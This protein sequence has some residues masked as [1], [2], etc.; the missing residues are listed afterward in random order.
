MN[1]TINPDA[2]LSARADERLAH[3][4][5]QIARAD[6]ELTRVTERLSRMESEAARG[7][8]TAYS[9]R[10]SRGGSGSR[11]LIAFLLAACIGGAA[12]ASHSSYGEAGR[13]MIA[14]LLPSYISAS[15]LSVARPQEAAQQGSSPVQLAAADTS[16]LQPTPTAQTP[17][18]VVPAPAAGAAQTPALASPDVM[19]MLQSMARD[20]ATVEQGIEQLKANQAQMAA[21]NA[22]AIEGLRASQEQ[23]TH[24][25]VRPP[26]KPAAKPALQPATQDARAKPPAPPPGAPKPVASAAHKPPPAAP[27]QARAHAQPVQLQPDAQ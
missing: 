7:P 17:V 18:Q 24:L 19:Q 10:S 6:D 14:P 5:E 8:A 4:Y 25:A 26:E 9:P 23:L 13:E 15:W 12:F 22:R 21:D 27:S 1:S 20:I 2:V 16:L 11:G 3:A